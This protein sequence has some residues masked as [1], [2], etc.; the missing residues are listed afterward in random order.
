M[1]NNIVTVHGW[2]TDNSIWRSFINSLPDD[3]NVYNPNLPGHGLGNK[4]RWPPSALSPAL[5]L[6]SEILDN[7]GTD[8]PP[9]G[10]GW[11][12]GALSL[13]KT[14]IE[15]P[16]SFRA[17]VLVSATPS[18]VSNNA[19][20]YGHSR[21]LVK[22]MILDLKSDPAQTLEMFYKLNFTGK[23]LESPEAGNFLDRYL[24]MRGELNLISLANSL[25]TL[26]KINIADEIKKLDLPVL[27]IHGSLDS[28]T[29]KEAAE[30]L[31]KNIKGARLEIIQDAGHAPFLTEEEKFNK[32][33]FDFI[34]EI[35][36]T[37]K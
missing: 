15:R 34:S 2:A 8:D 33:A 21:A 1:A 13:M 23:E 32:T 9:I 20:E 25:D 14:E 22:R 37:N 3:Y 10:I 18:F 19:F 28:V 6:I 30:F 17:L 36:A 35:F 31:E 4:A 7:I 16:G 12:L 24:N 27:I 11:S 26:Y 5:V 29:P